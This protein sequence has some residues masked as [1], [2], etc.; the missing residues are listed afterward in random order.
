ML[1]AQERDSTCTSFAIVSAFFFCPLQITYFFFSL[2]NRYY[3]DT[4][5]FENIF[6]VKLRS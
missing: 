1:I 6:E 5:H 3:F 4:S 2:D